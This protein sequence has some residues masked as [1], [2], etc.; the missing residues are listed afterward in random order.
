MGH[1]LLMLLGEASERSG[2][3]RYLKINTV[4]TRTMSLISQGTRWR[5][6]LHNLRDE[7]R[8]P[9]PTAYHQILREHAFFARALGLTSAF[10]AAE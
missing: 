5:G 7:R 10:R 1:G 9:L 2:M 6:K 3:D 8:V 4:K